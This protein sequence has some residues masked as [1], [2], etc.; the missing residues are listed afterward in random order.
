M[1]CKNCG[2]QLQDGAK[3]CP[4]CGRP[5]PNPANSSQQAHTQTPGGTGSAPQGSGYYSANGP[6][7]RKK[8]GGNKKVI[9]PIAAAAAVVVVGVGAFAMTRT[10]FFQSRFSDPVKYYK[11]VE[12]DAVEKAA[13]TLD[14]MAAKTFDS[15]KITMDVTLEDAGLAMMGLTG[16]DSDAIL[17]GV[18][19][20][21]AEINYGDKDGLKGGEAILYSG[22]EKLIS[23][24]A[25]IDSENKE[26]YIQ[27]PEASPGTLWINSQSYQDAS[28]GMLTSMTDIPD[29][30]SLSALLTSYADVVLENVDDVERESD[31][32]SVRSA[33][34]KATLLTV[35]VKDKQ[36]QNMII[37][38]MEKM[39]E[40]EDLKEYIVWLGDVAYAGYSY[41]YDSTSGGES[42]YQEFV[43]SLEREIEYMEDDSYFGDI[44]LKMHVWV[45]SKGEIIGRDMSASNGE[46]TIDLFS[47]KAVREKDD[48]ACEFSFGNTEDEYGDYVLV[49]G[50]G[51]Y[52]GDL[53]DGS[54]SIETYDAVADMT[55]ADYDTKAA[56]KGYLNGTFTFSG[57][58]DP[59]YA[60][61]GIQL[62]SAE[63]EN[64]MTQ[65]YSILSN[66][67][68]IA[69]LNMNI[70]RNTGYTPEIPDS[71]QL[72]DM[73]DYSAMSAY[74]DSMD[75]DALEASLRSNPLFNLLFQQMYWY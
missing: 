59:E 7:P 39:T 10:N 70:E 62:T 74:E 73:S 31:T 64:D 18:N 9:I 46:E 19:D 6:A 67:V 43:E 53:M 13:K 23:A 15:A 57:I 60:G 48:Y 20:L 27:I 50:S 32:L 4:R 35:T 1:F 28:L 71:S 21:E 8:K 38:L 30:S 14:N 56:E 12:K 40:D 24:N 36:L 58:P 25:V 55:I 34:Q 33:E 47:Y 37:D 69:T 3:F 63:S 17:Q 29:L 65:S 45:D 49:S 68:P 22:G 2:T 5:A 75:V 72:Y 51:S 42:Y 26:A 54:F 52:D 11:S 61:Y 66:D 16:S 44:T 41:S